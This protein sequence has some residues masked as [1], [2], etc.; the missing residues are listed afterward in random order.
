MVEENEAFNKEKLQEEYNDAY[1]F[2]T[3]F[4]GIILEVLAFISCY[5]ILW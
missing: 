3:Y 2:L 5:C 4:I 1:P